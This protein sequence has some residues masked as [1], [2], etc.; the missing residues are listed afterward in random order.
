[1][2]EE[3]KGR[4]EEKEVKS[5]ELLDYVKSVIHEGTAKKIVI[6]NKEGKDLLA[7]PLAVGVV[8]VVFAP[9]AMAIA[10]VIGMANEFTVV[11]E[12]RE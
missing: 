5:E 11:V 12:R 2:S 10:G 9:I 4:V 6:R 3:Q 8:G 7:V 1:M